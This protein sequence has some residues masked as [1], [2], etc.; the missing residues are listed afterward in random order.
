VGS[1]R[2]FER[3]KQIAG[4]TVEFLGNLKDSELKKSYQNAKAFLF[5]SKDEEFGI[6][7]VE[8]MG[9]GLPIIAYRSGGIPEYV[10]NA[11][12][13]F[14][15]DI[16]DP[17]SLIKKINELMGLSESKYL[18]MRKEARKTAERFT[19]EM[20]EKNILKFINSKL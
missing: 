4:P 8:A 20:F 3:L 16:L 1:G 7:V 13:G 11:K 18:E 14:L 2:D 10:I 6:A 12:N 17:S 19:E 9:Y 15:Y 5:A